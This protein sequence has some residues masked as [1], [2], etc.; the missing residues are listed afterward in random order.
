[1]T[2][3]Y[4]TKSIAKFKLSRGKDFVYERYGEVVEKDGRKNA[5]VEQFVH[6]E[7]HISE[8]PPPPANILLWIGIQMKKNVEICR[9]G[10]SGMSDFTLTKTEGGGY[11]YLTTK[12]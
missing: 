1:M 3:K 11:Q 2:S 9:Y 5:Y 12:V 10:K 7:N 8:S 6:S 4:V